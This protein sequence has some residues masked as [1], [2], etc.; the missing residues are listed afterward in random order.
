[1]LSQ[2]AVISLSSKFFPWSTPPDTRADLGAVSYGLGE[3]LYQGISALSPRR[4]DCS[5]VPPGISPLITP[6]P[7]HVI[8]WLPIRK[9]TLEKLVKPG[10][11]TSSLNASGR[12]V[13]AAE[14]IAVEW[15]DREIARESITLNDCKCQVQAEKES[16]P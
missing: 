16:E 2:L 3:T 11:P 15:P 9:F 7:P 1:M 8:R 6:V 10:P 13:F 5:C 14:R 4:P 12:G